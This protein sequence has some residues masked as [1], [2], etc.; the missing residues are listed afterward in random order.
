MSKS[1]QTVDTY[2]DE[3]YVEEDLIA[4]GAAVGVTGIIFA[5]VHTL[6]NLY[7]YALAKYAIVKGQKKNKDL[8]SKF[9]KLTK[10]PR[11]QV[12]QVPEDDPNAFVFGG[13]KI[14]VTTGLLKMLSEREVLAVVI[15]EYG[16]LV[17]K[18]VLKSILSQFPLLSLIWGASITLGFFSTIYLLPLYFVVLEHYG[19][20]PHNITIGR[21]YELQAD[22]MTRKYDLDKELISALEK[23][24]KWAQKIMSQYRC[25]FFCKAI[26][27]VEKMIDEH[28]SVKRRVEELLKDKKFWGF[29]KARKA[30]PLMKYVKQ[31]FGSENA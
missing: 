27:K 10:D 14:Y 15:H 8:T 1:L 31:K 17:N 5:I 22:A 28:P 12:Y 4:F 2:L 29:M 3:Q 30:V 11:Y 24:D 13:D 20:A 16:H 21:R 9:L 23:I 18:H 25:G 7:D 26:T 19:M 6:F